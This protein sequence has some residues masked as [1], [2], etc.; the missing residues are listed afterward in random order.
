MCRNAEVEIK[1]CFHGNLVN[2]YPRDGRWSNLT[3]DEI[4]S[5]Q[6]ILLDDLKAFNPKAL[7]AL[8]DET[9]AAFKPDFSDMEAERGAP[10]Y[11]GTVPSVCTFHPKQIFIQ[12][13][14]NPLV[15][16]DLAKAKK[17]ALNGWQP[18][19]FN[20]IYQPDFRTACDH[21]NRFIAEDAYLSVDIETNS[22]LKMTCIGFAYNPTSAITI[23][24]ITQNGRRYWNH[25]EETYI[26]RLVAKVCEKC[27]LIGHHALHFDHKVLFTSHRILPNFVD[28]TEFA[29]WECYPELLKGLGFCNSLYTDFPYWKDVLSQAR[30][31]LVE[32]WREYEYNSKDAITVF[33][34]A[35][36][37]KK[38]MSELPKKVFEHYRF[39]VRISRAFQYMG[40]R[41]VRFDTTKHAARL[42]ELTDE[43]NEL[44]KVFQAQAGKKLNIR[45]PKQINAWLYDELK[46]P[47]QFKTVKDD[48]GISTDKATTDYLAMLHL[49]RSFPEIPAILCGARLRRLFKR[50]SS[51]SKI[52]PRPDGRVGWDFNVVGTKTGRASGYKPLDDHGVQPQN[53]DSKDRDLFLADDGGY[54]GKGD[55][56]GADS[57]TIAAQCVSLGDSRMMD[58]LLGGVKPAQALAI[59][60]LFGHELIT[61]P[62]NVLKQYVPALKSK[63]KEEEASRGAKRSTYDGMKAVSHGSNYGMRE[64]TMHENIFKKSNGETWIPPKDCAFFQAL[65]YKR[66]PGINKVHEQMVRLM[67]DIGHLDSFSGTRR[68]F[69]SRRDNATVREMLSHLPQSHTNYA[70][71][72]L[73]ERMYYW[74]ENRER[75]V[76]LVMK[77]CNQVHDETCFL[78]QQERLEFVRELFYKMTELEME[79]WGVKFRI[80]F[81]VGYGPSWGDAKEEL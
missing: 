3:P 67:N 27:K 41:G 42:K 18:P 71:N 21:L 44:E 13:R 53:V 6:T 5:S 12:Y 39:N 63:T 9:A 60:H 55:L 17:Y 70:T 29:H 22:E 81:E 1:E 16:A 77:P 74:S 8:G 15:T 26:M 7:V 69:Y 61:A 75:K 64:Q 56:E 51:L 48:D 14:L 2:F 72:K 19:K 79:C 68:F 45:S 47:V 35:Y 49:A 50:T 10:F 20:I 24:F 73:I 66:Y 76:H 40:I 37:I 23:P 36:E 4:A 43:A 52:I 33:S 80:P 28:D 38:E 34:C 25:T 78:F 31:G 57:W 32:Y 59:A 11:W 58:D 65:M 46:L 54:W 62:T 30:R